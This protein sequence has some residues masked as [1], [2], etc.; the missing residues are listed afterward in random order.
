MT[1]AWHATSVFFVLLYLKENPEASVWLRFINFVVMF[2]GFLFLIWI[3]I[4]VIS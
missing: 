4:Q 1:I 3:K 2:L